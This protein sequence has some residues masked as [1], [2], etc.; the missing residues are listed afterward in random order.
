VC[1]PKW[2]V[3]LRS[4]LIIVVLILLLIFLIQAQSK[5]RY[6]H[7][8]LRLLINHVQLILL[9]STFHF[10]WPVKLQDIFDFSRPI[11]QPFSE[12]LSLGCLYSDPSDNTDTIKQ[13]F[14]TVIFLALL[15][16]IFAACTV[17]Y[18]KARLRCQETKAKRMM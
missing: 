4:F 13:F 10:N 8:F 16:L 7:V 2:W 9:I 15:P 5:S 6:L 17:I 12:L 11:S 18:W 14:S 1:P 3:L